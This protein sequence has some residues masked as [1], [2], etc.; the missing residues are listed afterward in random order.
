ML[1]RGYAPKTI[2]NVHNV[3]S[4]AMKHALRMELVNR[5]PVSMV[6]A[7]STRKQIKVPPPPIEVVSRLL[8]IAEDTEHPLFPCIHSL[9]TPECVGARRWP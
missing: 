5:N 8:R 7:P 4:G 2:A 6:S 9:P 3:L 1:E